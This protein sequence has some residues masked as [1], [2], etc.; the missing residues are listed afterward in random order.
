MHFSENIL[1]FR[2]YLVIAILFLIPICFI[3]TKELINSIL[4]LIVVKRIKR[5]SIQ[6]TNNTDIVRLLQYYLKRQKWL[7]CILMLESYKTTDRINYFNLLGIC[8]QK[9]ACYIVAEYYYLKAT[10]HDSTNITILQ[11]LATIYKL[12][13]KEYELKKICDVI[14]SLDSNNSLAKKYLNIE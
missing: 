1:I 14:L 7:T 10:K 11:N 8:Y 4:Y 2:L 6:Q 9:V 12:L 5:I 3:I 13:Y